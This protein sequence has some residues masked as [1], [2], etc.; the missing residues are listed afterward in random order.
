MKVDA[1]TLPGLMLAS[2][3]DATPKIAQKVTR[4]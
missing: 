2:V 4:L 1:V 3:L